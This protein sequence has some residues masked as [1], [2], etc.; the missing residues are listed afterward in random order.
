MRCSRAKSS[1]PRHGLCTHV[2]KFVSPRSAASSSDKSTAVCSNRFW[3]RSNEQSGMKSSFE[4][5]ISA[6]ALRTS[7]RSATCIHRPLKAGL[8]RDLIAGSAWRSDVEWRLCGRLSYSAHSGCGHRASARAQWD[9]CAAG[10]PGDGRANRSYDRAETSSS[11]V[12]LWPWSGRT[13][14][15][16]RATSVSR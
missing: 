5:E 8:S 6:K 13:Y 16:N 4:S 1:R 15:S 14:Q 9:R 11:S 12:S 2:A 7:S 3:T 10:R